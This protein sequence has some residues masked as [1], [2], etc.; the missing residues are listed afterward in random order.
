[1]QRWLRTAKLYDGIGD[2]RCTAC[3]DERMR[4]SS[5][6]AFRAMQDENSSGGAV[7]GF[8]GRAKNESPFQRVAQRRGAAY[9]RN[10]WG[11]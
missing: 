3:L 11:R 4:G 6:V 1:M 9:A 5:T 7:T 10:C 8:V 2:W